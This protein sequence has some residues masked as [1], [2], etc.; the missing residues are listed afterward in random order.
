[1]C[2][3]YK[4]SLLLYLGKL[5]KNEKEIV[6]RISSIEDDNDVFLVM[7]QKFTANLNLLQQKATDL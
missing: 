3:N 4:V 2:S 5:L 6:L 1:M 7:N